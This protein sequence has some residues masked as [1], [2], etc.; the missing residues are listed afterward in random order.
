MPRSGR[1]GTGACAIMLFRPTIVVC[2]KVRRKSSYRLD[3]KDPE[4]RGEWI[5]VT[6]RLNET[7]LF[8]SPRGEVS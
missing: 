7:A 5:L 2:G 4:N 6:R 8:S 3:E 1:A